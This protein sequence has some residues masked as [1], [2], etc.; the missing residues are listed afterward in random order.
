MV[1]DLEFHVEGLKGSGLGG[2]QGSSNPFIRGL[3]ERSVQGRGHWECTSFTRDPN[4][5][6]NLYYGR[7]RD[8]HFPKLPQTG[9]QIT[10][11][12]FKVLV[13][14]EGLPLRNLD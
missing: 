8:L 12:R 14:A 2:A 13:R 6:G 9:A 10:G 3:L 1:R 7:L 4:L 11:F 5:E